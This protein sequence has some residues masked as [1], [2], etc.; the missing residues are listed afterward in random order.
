MCQYEPTNCKYLLAAISVVVTHKP[1]E[2]LYMTQYILYQVFTLQVNT[3]ILVFLIYVHFYKYGWQ[4]TIESTN[5]MI[6]NFC[7]SY[8]S[9]YLFAKFERKLTASHWKGY[10]IMASGIYWYAFLL[11]NFLSICFNKISFGFSK[12]ITFIIILR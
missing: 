7:Y 4:Q 8:Y 12:N 2:R 11:Q 3:C 1:M 9:K 5:V 10:V 6:A